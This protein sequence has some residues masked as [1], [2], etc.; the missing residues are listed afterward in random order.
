MVL[1]NVLKHLTLMPSSNLLALGHL[2]GQV[3]CQ[4]NY[5]YFIIYCIKTQKIKYFSYNKYHGGGALVVIR[6][7]DISKIENCLTALLFFFKC[8]ILPL[9]TFMF[10]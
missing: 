2:C 4:V 1:E 10:L 8:Q 3:K 9:D 7:L 5:K 6:V